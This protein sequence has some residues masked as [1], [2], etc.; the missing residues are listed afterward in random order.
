MRKVWDGDDIRTYRTNVENSV[1][2]TGNCRGP[3]KEDRTGEYEI[4]GEIENRKK[5]QEYEQQRKMNKSV[6]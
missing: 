3:R 6:K 1:G 2:K 5:K 4:G